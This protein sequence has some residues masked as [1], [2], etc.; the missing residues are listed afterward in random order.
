MLHLFTRYRHISLFLL[1]LFIS[2][3][4]LS[5]HRTPETG[6]PPA[7]I[8]ERGMLLILEP[9][10]SMASTVTLQFQELWNGYLALVHLSEENQRLR[11][12]IQQLRAE[13]NRYIEDALAYERLKGTVDLI[14]QRQFSTILAR[15]IGIDASNHS[16][17]I[18]VNRGSDDGIQESWPV[19]TLDGIVGVTISVSKR[20]SKI[21]LMT[22]PNCN[23]AALIQ[24]TRDQGIVGGVGRKD[25][26]SMKYV[27]R[28]AIIRE[29][30]VFRLTDQS[31][32][33]LMNEDIPGFDLTDPVFAQLRENAIPE[34]I[35][36]ILEELQNRLYPNQKAFI[37]ALD[38]T[39]GK[40]QAEWYTP[41]IVQY[42]QTDV[43]AKLRQIKDQ[44]FS[45]RNE[46]LNALAT[47]IGEKAAQT[48]QDVI[49]QHVQEEEAVISSG[50][51]GIF[52]KGLKVGTVSK[53]VKQDYGLFQEIEVTPG[54][55]FSK[56]E[57]VLIIR[58]DEQDPLTAIP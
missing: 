52:P 39:L 22:D 56:L 36:V 11:E 17:T 1:F 6:I 58:R 49:L 5:F 16:H 31:L 46:F 25:T 55:D 8:L 28:R 37:R 53:V 9:F 57:E 47:A 2:V 23:V 27:N 19:I 45:T 35:L 34:D 50:L 38:Q 15:V 42:A 24:R 44:E 48:Y 3:T 4:L 29:G 20:S 10:Q 43:L 33:Q 30:E 51:G 12:E 21:L 13:K 40:E 32:A 54:V 18:V 14:E 26:Y 7:N 41:M